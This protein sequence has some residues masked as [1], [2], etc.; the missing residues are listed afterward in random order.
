MFVFSFVYWCLLFVCTIHFAAVKLQISRC[1]TNKGLFYFILSDLF[2]CVALKRRLLQFY[3]SRKCP[4][5][6]QAWPTNRHKYPLHCTG[7]MVWRFLNFNSTLV[8]YLYILKVDLECRALSYSH[9]D[10]GS[11]S[12]RYI[13]RL[14]KK[15]SGNPVPSLWEMSCWP[16]VSECALQLLLCLKR[17][18]EEY[19]I[20][21]LLLYACDVCCWVGFYS[22]Y[23]GHRFTSNT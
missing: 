23:W 8:L 15:I 18:L 2:V 1:G 9:E 19:M 20:A 3:S 7:N 4:V 13:S 11:F 16:L 6:I 10:R 12:H 5:K 22:G 17:P 14:V 21:L